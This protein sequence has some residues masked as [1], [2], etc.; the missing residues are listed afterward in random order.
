MT[1]IVIFGLTEM[2]VKRGHG[3]K[4]IDDVVEVNSYIILLKK[5]SNKVSLEPQD[6]TEN[7]LDAFR[8]KL[9]DDY[10]E[11]YF[12][13]EK[14][15][16]EDVSPLRISQ[17]NDAQ[18]RLIQVARISKPSEALEHMDTIIEYRALA[19]KDLKS[20]CESHIPRASVK[21]KS[22]IIF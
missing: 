8:E 12:I 18:A 21:P 5:Y 15:C 7:I 11:I 19:T 1:Y 6:T 22:C 4:Y 17:M 10:N 16:K 14:L 13:R 2:A 9:Y 20:W 3:I